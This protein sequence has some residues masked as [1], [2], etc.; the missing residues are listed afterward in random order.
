MTNMTYVQAIDNA[1][2]IINTAL[3]TDPNMWENMDVTAEKLE[4]LKAQLEKRTGGK[5]TPTKTQKENELIMDQILLTLEMIGEPV[6]VTELLEYGIE[7]YTLT[8]QKTSALLRKLIENG[9]VV[10]TIEGKKAKFAL[11]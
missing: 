3:A 9:K 10:K 2:E 1:L 6:T 11:A 5:K 8:N 7:G 4:A